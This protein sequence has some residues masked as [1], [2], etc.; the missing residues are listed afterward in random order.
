MAQLV[1]HLPL[2][3]V[4]ISGT[5]DS[6]HIRIPAQWEAHFF[7][8]F[9]PSPQLCSFS[10]RNKKNLEKEK[11][12]DYALDIITA[13]IQMIAVLIIHKHACMFISISYYFDILNFS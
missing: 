8:S 2:A 9:C 13:G 6:A 4:L 11:N 7:F 3:Q 1:K 12:I 5:W 10:Q